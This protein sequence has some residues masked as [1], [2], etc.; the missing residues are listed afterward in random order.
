MSLMGIGLLLTVFLT[1]TPLQAEERVEITEPWGTWAFV[2]SDFKKRHPFW[3]PFM[4]NK[5][6]KSRLVLTSKHFAQHWTAD[7]VVNDPEPIRSVVTLPQGGWKLTRQNED[8][9]RVD[10]TITPRDERWFYTEGKLKYQVIKQSAEQI[11]AW[12][13][14]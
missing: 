13:E 9:K 11:K 6:M 7:D 2:K 14:H 3:L 12:K 1:S 8:G 5:A 10:F 4:I